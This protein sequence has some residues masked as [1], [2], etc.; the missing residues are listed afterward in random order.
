MNQHNEK[1]HS[2]WKPFRAAAAGVLLACAAQAG[3]SVT[4]PAIGQLL[5][6]EEFNGPSLD[7][8][9][10]TATDGNGCQINLCGYGN[11]ELEYYS[12]NNVSIADVPFEPGT[13]ALAIRAQN[14]TVGSNVFTSGKIDTHNKVQVQYGMIEIRMSTPNIATGL[15]PAAWMLGTSPQT[16]PRNGEID[17]MEMGHKASVRAAAG[18]PSANNFVGSNVITWQQAACVPGNESCAASTAWQTKNWYVPTT[19]LANRF[20]TYRLYWTESEMRFT[21]VDNGVERNMYDAPLPVNSTALQAPF[22]LLLNLAVGGNFTDAAT[23]GQVTAP[24]PGTMYVDYVRVYQ[25]DGKGSVKL[26]N[27]T[28]PEVAG[29][30][31]VFTDNTPVNNKLVAGTS[32]DIFLW[33]GASSGAGN[34]PAYEG[35]NVIAWAYT[36][37]GQWFGGGVQARQARDLTNYRNGTMK[38]RIK[39]PANVSFNIGVGDTYTNQNWVNFPANTTAYG[40][41]RNGDWAQASIPV[42][43]LIGPKV[44]LQ[45]LLDI[46]MISSDANKLPASAFQFAIDDIVWD[47]GTTTTPP[48]SGPTYVTQTSATTLQFT[49]TTGSWADVHYTVNNGTQQNVRMRLDGTTNTYS[50]G[51]LKIGDVVRYSFTYWDAARNFAVDTAQQT[52]TMQ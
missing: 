8:S 12:P 36:A 48:P 3:A 46:F 40:L 5:W 21:T 17:I 38:F 32:S 22:Y 49:T 45:S 37:P 1:S 9:R 16:W 51:G 24:L 26:G 10:W 52:Y 20:V 28:V 15:W 39:I 35:S 18:S 7:A 6:S 47:S 19:S 4:S 27:Q 2:Q 31:G 34:T 13:R 29:K 14:Q 33:N 25:L 50:A 44:A 11:Q 42:S 23:P 41:V 43:T 30:F